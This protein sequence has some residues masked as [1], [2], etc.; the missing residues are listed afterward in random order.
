MTLE[1]PLS[2]Q[3]EWFWFNAGKATSG[4]PRE[5]QQAIRTLLDMASNHE[6]DRL[7][8]RA[9]SIVATRHWGSVEMMSR[10]PGGDAG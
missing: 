3:A 8:T 10:R 2:S 5:R 4:D 9:A 6:D 7:R 1:C